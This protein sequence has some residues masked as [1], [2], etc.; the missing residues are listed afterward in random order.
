MYICPHPMVPLQKSCLLF[1]LNTLISEI[2]DTPPPLLPHFHI[3]PCLFLVCMYIYPK[4]HP[5][6][7]VA[8]VAME[9]SSNVWL[10]FSSTA[11]VR[12]S[13]QIS[14]PPHSPLLTLA[15]NLLTFPPFLSPSN[16]VGF[17]LS[18]SF[19][20]PTTNPPPTACHYQFFPNI[21]SEG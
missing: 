10:H 14:T 18:F 6:H 19:L 1:F 7:S 20:P 11:P 8:R 3:C 12:S 15:S 5:N 4:S 2:I 13:F 16:P 9:D 21:T 17:G